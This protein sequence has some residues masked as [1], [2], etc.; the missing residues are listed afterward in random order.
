VFLPP[1]SDRGTIKV[2]LQPCFVETKQ[3]MD[4]RTKLS[5]AL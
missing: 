5:V 4:E 1:P 3:I 2:M